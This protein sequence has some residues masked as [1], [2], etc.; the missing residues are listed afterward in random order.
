MGKFEFF[1]SKE[2]AGARID[3]FLAQQDIGL[4]RSA[5]QQLLE[6]GLVCCD[7]KSVA[8]N[9]KIQAGTIVEIQVPDAQPLFT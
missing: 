7:G 9:T 4:S 1:I 2:Q 8:K 6:K 3:S 5:V